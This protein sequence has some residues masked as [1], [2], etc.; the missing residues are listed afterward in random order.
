M[1]S[2]VRAMISARSSGVRVL[3]EC[4]LLNVRVDPG[5]IVAHR[6]LAQLAVLVRLVEPRNR[7]TIFQIRLAFVFDM[8]RIVSS[9][10][11]AKGE[12]TPPSPHGVD[13]A[14][15]PRGRVRPVVTAQLWWAN[16]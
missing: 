16:A 8:A 14:G 12:G 2:S 5:H 13:E 3:I 15:S 11:V 6:A 10:L 7:S 4:P 1:R 9:P